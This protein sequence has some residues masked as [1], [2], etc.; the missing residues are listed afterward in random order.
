M[1]SI[2]WATVATAL[3]RCPQGA[4]L[5]LP[6]ARMEHPSQGGLR[7]SIAVP[8]GQLAT[9]QRA[10]EG[11][12]SLWVRDF[13]S[14]YDASLERMLPVVRPLPDDSNPIVSGAAAGSLV[15]ALLGRSTAALFIGAAL[16]G[17]LAALAT[18]NSNPA[19]MSDRGT[20]LGTSERSESL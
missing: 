19:Q 8:R 15:G 14:H 2:T 20:A 9:Y 11:S 7:L 16:G 5:R 10:L 12:S 3:H 18:T 13:G 6:K 4:V 1:S 17:A